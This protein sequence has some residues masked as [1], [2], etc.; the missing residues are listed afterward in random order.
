MTNIRDTIFIYL[1][2]VREAPSDMWV[3]VRDANLAYSLI[4]EFARSGYPMVVSLDHDLGEN[5]STGYDLLNWLEKDIVTDENFRPDVC[6]QIH[7]ANPVGRA[8]MER[9]IGAIMR[10]M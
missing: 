6:F 9:A 4:I 2:D 10:L 1:D 8:N 3:V 5:V 7:S